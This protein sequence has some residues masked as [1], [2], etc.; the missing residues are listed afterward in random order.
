MRLNKLIF[1]V[2]LKNLEILRLWL[3][4]NNLTVI[5]YDKAG[6]IIPAVIDNKVS[7]IEIDMR[8]DAL[9]EQDIFERFNSLAGKKIIKEIDNAIDSES[10]KEA[11]L[12]TDN[13]R[14]LHFFITEIDIRG[15]NS[16]TYYLDSKSTDTDEI[17]DTFELYKSEFLGN[18]IISEQEGLQALHDFESA[19]NQLD[20]F[21]MI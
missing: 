6:N 13:A 19:M 20:L 15:L 8:R 2:Q 7:S 9:S 16:V 11:G 10:E 21:P 5:R 3:M 12:Y 18:E 4:N 14:N 17:R 1:Q